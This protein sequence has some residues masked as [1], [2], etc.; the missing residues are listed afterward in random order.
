M[1]Q[2]RLLLDEGMPARAAALL[3]ARGVPTEHILELAL[4][5]HSDE[6][7]IAE[8]LR[9]G[10]VV[11]TLDSDFHDWLARHRAVQP[12]V[13]RVRIEGLKGPQM[14]SLLER[15]VDQTRESLI[16]GTAV[17]VTPHNIRSRKLPLSPW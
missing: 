10:A 3:T 1:N 16:T 4:G 15:V 12:S 17:S 9:R 6:A 7:I 8:A 11:A 13:I 14:A 2:V 5:G